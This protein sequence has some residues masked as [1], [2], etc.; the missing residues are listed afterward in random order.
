MRSGSLLPPRHVLALHCSTARIGTQSPLIKVKLTHLKCRALF[1]LGAGMAAVPADPADPPL[2]LVQ[3]GGAGTE[4]PFGVCFEVSMVRTRQG[5]SLAPGCRARCKS[6][7]FAEKGRIKY[8]RKWQVRHT[9]LG[10][11]QMVIT[12]A[13]SPGRGCTI[14]LRCG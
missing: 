12:K 4:L 5:P 3:G 9:Y 11:G 2:Q 6:R 1:F 7:P 8:F 10:G 14:A 13:I